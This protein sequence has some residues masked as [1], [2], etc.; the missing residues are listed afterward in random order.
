MK[1]V[2][3]T[4]QGAGFDPDGNSSGNGATLNLGYK[5]ML[6]LIEQLKACGEVASM[7]TCNWQVYCQREKSEIVSIILSSYVHFLSA[8]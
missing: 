7:R 2:M 8:F 6:N 5:A 3:D 1:V 4:C